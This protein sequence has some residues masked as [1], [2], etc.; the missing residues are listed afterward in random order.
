MP[1]EFYQ[2]LEKGEKGEE[3]AIDY[4]SN[5]FNF[6]EFMRV[7][8]IDRYMDVDIDAIVGDRDDGGAFAL[9]IKCDETNYKS[10]NLFVEFISSEK[11]NTPGWLHKSNADYIAYMF[12]NKGMFIMCKL[13]DLK[14]LISK[15][16]YK[17]GKAYD[18]NKKVSIGYLIPVED[19][20]NHINRY[21]DIYRF[22]DY[23]C[24]LE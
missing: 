14:E 15:H 13:D 4:L 6:L 22:C 3:I 10:N 17:T 16:K 24:V 5:K 1:Q 9:E 8:K 18:K 20:V 12:K 7:N 19:V 2:S 21:K 11:Y 23:N